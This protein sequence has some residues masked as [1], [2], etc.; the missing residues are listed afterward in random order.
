MCSYTL[1][2]SRTRAPTASPALRGTVTVLIAYHNATPISI[3]AAHNCSLAQHTNYKCS[4]HGP[5]RFRLR[6]Q[7]QR[8]QLSQKAPACRS[9]SSMITAIDLEHQKNSDMDAKCQPACPERI[10]CVCALRTPI[11]ARARANEGEHGHLHVLRARMVR[12]VVPFIH[13]L[14]WYSTAPRK[15]EQASIQPNTP[16]GFMASVKGS[17]AAVAR[18][19]LLSRRLGTKS[20]CIRTIWPA[21]APK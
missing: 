2:W 13:Q 6:I 8:Q 4:S 11:C 7:Q 20:C 9:I 17:A 16:C 10:R 5:N 3:P 15:K 19:P 12:G 1:F 14:S 18:V 21:A